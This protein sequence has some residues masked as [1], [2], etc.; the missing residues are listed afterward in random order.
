MVLYVDE[1]ECEE[2]FIVT[3]LLV[4]NASD[5]NDAY[6]RFKKNIKGFSIP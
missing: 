2:F 5:V 6:K 1:T 4:E 3:G